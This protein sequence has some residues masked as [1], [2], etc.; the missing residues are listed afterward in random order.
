MTDLAQ[1]EKDNEAFLIKI[2]QVAPVATT[3]PTTKKDEE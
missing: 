3:K 2:G 1:W